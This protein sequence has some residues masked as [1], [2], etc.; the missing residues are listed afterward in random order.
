MLRGF[1]LGASDWLAMPV[2]ENEL[3]ARARNQIRRKFYQDRFRSDL[4]TALELALTDPLTS[5]YNQR[6]LRRHLTG[7]M[8]S[9]QGRPIA[10]LMIDV[11]HFKVG[12]RPVRPRQWRHRAAA[13]R[14]CIPQQHPRVRLAGPLRRRGIRRRDARLQPRRRDGRG[15][16]A[17]PGGRRSRRS[18]R[19]SS[20][21]RTK[22]GR[23]LR[24][25][26][27]SRARREPQGKA[28]RGA[29]EPKIRF[30]ETR[31]RRGRA[32]GRQ[33]LPG[34]GRGAFGPGGFASKGAR[35]GESRRRRL[36]GARPGRPGRR[37]RPRRPSSRRPAPS[38]RNRGRMRTPFPN[39]WRPTRL[40]SRRRAIP[41]RRPGPS[42]RSSK[43]RKAILARPR[44][45]SGRRLR[46]PWAPRRREHRGRPSR[47]PW[48]GRSP[49][50]RTGS[51]PR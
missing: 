28:R 44:P 8:Q 5:L 40:R 49:T 33:R 38:S 3:R 9:G 24:S 39:A 32:Q 48:T 12:Q 34:K 19:G 43:Q 16:A 2:D 10:V 46:T 35:S 25:R 47:R 30:G 41:V 13:D 45:S 18:R 37:S 51:P 14:R 26:G 4:S 29:K 20:A 42:P 36:Q 11:D 22:P 50:S 23:F 6:Y 1:E 31:L 15:R 21:G 27:A 17:A 7:L